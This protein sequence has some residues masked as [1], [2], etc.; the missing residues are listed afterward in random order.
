MNFEF[1]YIILAHKNPKQ[2]VRLLNRLNSSN[3]KVSFWIHIDKRSNFKDF[4]QALKCFENIVWIPSQFTRWGS[5]QLVKVVLWAL[6]DIKNKSRS[7]RHVILLSGQDYPI[8]NPD[9]IYSF[10][11]ENEKSSFIE[12]EPL[13]VK[14]LKF[15]GLDRFEKWH[16]YIGN[17][18]LTFPLYNKNYGI[19]DKIIQ[20]ILCNFLPH[21][22]ENLNNITLYYGS[23]WW[24]LSFN[25]VEYILDFV[26][27]NLRFVDF[28]KYSWISDEHFFQTILLNNNDE[29]FKYSC[30]N[31]NL[32]YYDWTKPN[33][34]PPAFLNQE[35][36][37]KIINSGKFFARKFDENIDNEILNQLDE[38]QKSNL[39]FKKGK[40]DLKE[41]GIK[42]NKFR[43]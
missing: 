34:R 41:S 15:G 2:L 37:N 6:F 17:R 8:I 36:Y 19:L 38:Y 4:H 31:N 21:K 22:K 33:E 11:N 26:N 1:A 40:V 10:L 28:F 35:D 23:Q 30:I 12:Y 42:I 13:P 14:N 16:F 27:N 32:R 9:N 18:K 5:F 43:L 20:A 29:L 7:Y 3:F 24:I 25:C 39:T